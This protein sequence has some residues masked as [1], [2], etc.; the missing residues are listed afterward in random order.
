MHLN[1]LKPGEGAIARIGRKQIAAYRDDAGKLH[2]LSA[3][4]THL[5]C[6][7]S[8]NAADRAWECPCHGSRFAADGALVQGPATA[9]LAD[10][11]T[12]LADSE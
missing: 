12:A 9:D 4:C 3:R 1:T 8:W 5:G 7:I 11:S 2:V 10:E 6:I